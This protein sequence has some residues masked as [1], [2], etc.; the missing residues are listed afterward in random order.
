MVERLDCRLGAI[1]PEGFLDRRCHVLGESDDGRIVRGID[2]LAGRALTRGG[3]S[4]TNRRQP[5]GYQLIGDRSL[6]GGEQLEDFVEVRMTGREA[7]RSRSDR[8]GRRG[9][10]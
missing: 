10:P 2:L 4:P 6:L 5:A 1:K 9:A 8:T 3:E 7:L